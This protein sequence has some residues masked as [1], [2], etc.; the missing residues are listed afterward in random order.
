MKCRKLSNYQLLKKD[1]ELIR[2]IRY[3]NTPTLCVSLS[4]QHGGSSGFGWR[5]R[6]ADVNSSCEYIEYADG[7]VLQLWGW[8]RGHQLLTVKKEK[9]FTK[10]STGPRN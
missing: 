8:A 1:M 9:L 4:P 10:C 6:P 2:L 3:Y 5:R 7:V